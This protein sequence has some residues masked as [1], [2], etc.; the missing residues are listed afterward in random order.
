MDVR[1]EALPSEILIPYVWIYHQR[2]NTADMLVINFSKMEIAVFLNITQCRLT[3]SWTTFWR[4]CLYLQGGHRNE[5]FILL[6]LPLKLEAES[7]RG[8]SIIG[9]PEIH[10]HS[11]ED[12]PSLPKAAD[13]SDI[14]LHF[15]AFIGYSDIN[16]RIWTRNNTMIHL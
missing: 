15:S 7:Y 12:R 1:Q 10:L 8:T 13:T 14:Q 3:I 9:Y 4:S 6:G 11:P 5:L 2:M 16:A